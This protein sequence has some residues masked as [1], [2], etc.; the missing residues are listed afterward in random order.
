MWTDAVGGIADLL[1]ALAA[2]LGAVGALWL[3]LRKITRKGPK[4]P[5][6]ETGA[7]IPVAFDY[8]TQWRIEKERA[9]RLDQRLDEEQDKWSRRLEA[10]RDARLAA[11]RF[12]HKLELILTR[13]NIPF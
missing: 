10:E 11:E 12:A 3:A 8:P 5:V 7:E 2:F 1:G 9:D 13:N 6:M 4:E